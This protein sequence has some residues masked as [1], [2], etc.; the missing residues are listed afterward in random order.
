MEDT[1]TKSP[2]ETRYAVQWSKPLGEGAFGAVY[3]ATDRMTGDKVAVKK[4]NKEFT[5]DVSFQREMNALMH[6]R[7]NGGHPNICSLRENYTEGGHYYLVLDLVSGG[8]MFDHLVNLGAY[9]EA[10]AARLVRE[11]ASALAFIHG[12]DTVHGDMKP[13][14][15]MLSSE[16][17]SDAVIKLVDFGCAQVDAKDSAFPGSREL[18]NT[19]VVNTPAYCPPEVL[20]KKRAKGAMDQSMDMWALGVILFIMLTGIILL[21]DLAFALLS[22]SHSSFL[23]LTGVHPFDLEGDASEETIKRTVLKRQGPPLKGS[24]ITAHLSPDAIDVIDK[25]MACDPKK[26]MTAAQMLDHPWVRGETARHDK[27]ADSDNKLSMYRGFKSRL[28]LKVFEDIVNWSDENGSDI[29]KSTS[30]FERAF[31]NLD[32]QHKGYITAT[33][34]KRL[35]IDDKGKAVLTDGAEQEEDLPLTLSGFSDLLSDHMRNKYFPKGHIIYRQGDEGNHMYLLN[36]GTVEITTKKGFH[37]EL[38]QGE[39]F[40]EG[41]SIDC[42]HCVESIRASNV[43]TT[44]HF[45]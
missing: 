40:G 18:S 14:N 37:T 16:N 29:S 31:H 4:I 10:A 21:Y 28:E 1:S 24:P 39:F 7:K 45:L 42:Y 13:E 19:A 33:D 44:I 35:A 23:L 34:L 36:S 32:P 20:D 30:L 38:S 11:V 3:L 25:L 6:L 22:A 43:N 26:R 12:L 8:E 41:K 27:I 5:D 2:L 17:P 9:S 15:V